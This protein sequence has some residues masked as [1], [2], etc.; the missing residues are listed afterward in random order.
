MELIKANL[1]QAARY[2]DEIPALVHATG[3]VSYDYHFGNPVVFDA[4]VKR[5][6]LTPDTLFSHDATTLAVDGDELLGVFTER[7][8]LLK[9]NVD[10]AELKDHPVSEY[11]TKQPRTL[12]ADDKIAFALHRMDLGG[13]RHLPIMKDGK[14]TG[15]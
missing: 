15:I 13:Y 1:D 9:L 8:A 5:S 11:M 10:Y 14:P 2:T 3:P 6:W 4:M 12:A 7:D